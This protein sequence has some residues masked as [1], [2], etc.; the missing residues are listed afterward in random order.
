MKAARI[1]LG[2]RS[3]RSLRPRPMRPRCRCSAGDGQ[4]GHF[5]FGE[6]G[7][8]LLC[9]Y[10]KTLV[11]AQMRYTVHDRHGHLLALL[12]FSTAARKLAPRDRF[13]GWTEPLREKNLPRVIDNARFLILPWIRI[14]NLASHILSVV[15]RQLPGQWTVRYNV[16]PVLIETFVETP[17][18][19]GGLYR[20]SGWTHIGT[21][22]GRGRY[23]RHK[24]YNKPKKAIWLRPLRK[25]WK[26]RLNR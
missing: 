24:K 25:D 12:G 13:I 21:T 3:L 8:F 26:R 7:T 1:G 19:T 23:D 20:A 10:N 2:L 4:R 14:P 16:T 9:V 17:R 18:F 6:K 11:G 22:Q 15:C 5:C